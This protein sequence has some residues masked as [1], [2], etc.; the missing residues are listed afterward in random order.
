MVVRK[1]YGQR[2]Q[3]TILLSF[4]HIEQLKKMSKDDE[5]L[6]CTIRRIIEEKII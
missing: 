4:D 3:I 5:N 2:K 6:Q 1:V